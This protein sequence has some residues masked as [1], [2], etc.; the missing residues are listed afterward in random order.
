MKITNILL[1]AASL[2][3]GQIFAQT[4]PPPN[5]PTQAE[6]VQGLKVGDVAPDFSLKDQNGKIIKLSEQLKHGPVVLTWYRGGWC[7]YCNVALKALAGHLDS[8]E[9]QGARLFALTPELPERSAETAQKNGVPFGVLTDADNKVAQLYKLVFKLDDATAKRYEAAF[10]LSGF[11]GNTKAELPVP[12]TYVIDTKGIVR[13]AYV[14]PNYRERAQPSAVVQALQTINAA[15]S[16]KLVVLWTSDDPLLA[17]RFIGMYSQAS[18]RNKWFGEVRII[19]W[20]PASKLVAENEK[21][22]A[23]LA[24]MKKNGII[25]QACI[26]C[27]DAYGVSDALRA[28]G[29]EVKGMGQPLTRFIKQGYRVL[30]L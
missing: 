2:F 26:A 10:K 25:L 30:T 24:S 3:G 23:L 21:M 1:I 7:P 9:G 17:E 20:G 16:N 11:N 29:V 5:V 22:K 6:A 27:S 14:N 13:Y 15:N 4:S 8:I 18:A 12:A 28:Q 19:L